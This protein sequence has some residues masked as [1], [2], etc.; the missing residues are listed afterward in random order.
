MKAGTFVSP[1]AKASKPDSTV[2]FF[3]SLGR[4][5]ETKYMIS[6][7]FFSLLHWF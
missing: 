2:P 4:C 5:K 1:I 7:N 3:P 6:W